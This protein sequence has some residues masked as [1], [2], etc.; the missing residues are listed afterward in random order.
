MEMLIGF[1][2]LVVF[3]LV[4]WIVLQGRHQNRQADIQALLMI[5]QH[6]EALRHQVQTQQ[7]AMT[8][9]LQTMSGHVGNRLDSTAQLVG[10]VRQSVG[11]LTKAAEQ[12]YQVGKDITSLQDILQSP[13]LRGNLGEFFLQDMLAQVLPGAFYRIQHRFRSGAIVD[14]VIQIGNR[15]VP[16]DAKFPLENFRRH[17]QA[18]TSAEK[19]EQA[20]RRFLADTK[21]HIDAI[22]SKYILPDEGTYDFALMYI[23]AENV[24]YEVMLRGEAGGDDLLPY[25]IQRK[26]FPVSPVSLYAYLQTIVLGLR[27]LQLEESAQEVL[28]QL[29]R[30]QRDTGLLREAF[31]VLGRHLGNAH[32][33]YDEAGKLLVQLEGKLLTLAPEQQTLT[34]GSPHSVPEQRITES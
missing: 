27:G 4:L 32:N 9:H 7:Q 2:A 13:K 24:Y 34:P 33:K 11:M 15:R 28:Q 5:Q 3:C 29:A 12:M 10:E 17:L 14:A 30:L 22:A 18:G 31:E 6:M 26:V 16:V 19:P 8:Q 23:P 1:L 25:A 20:R 21:R